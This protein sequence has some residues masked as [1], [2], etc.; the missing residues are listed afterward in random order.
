VT[1][2]L[3]RWT[4]GGSVGEERRRATGG[5][6]LAL[7]TPLCSLARIVILSPAELPQITYYTRSCQDEEK[8]RKMRAVK[9]VHAIA[10]CVIIKYFHYETKTNTRARRRS[11]LDGNVRC[12]DEIVVERR[13][14]SWRTCAWVKLY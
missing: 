4:N 2:S 14:I 9:I 6:G 11:F 13:W 8:E 12:R 5:Y 7:P 1:F 10:A 3:G